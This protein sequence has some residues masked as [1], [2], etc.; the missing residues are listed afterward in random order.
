MERASQELEGKGGILNY[1]TIEFIALE[2]WRYGTFLF[3][4]TERPLPLGTAATGLF[5]TMAVL[6]VSHSFSVRFIS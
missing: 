4:S 6:P 2:L 3:L 5:G 1:R